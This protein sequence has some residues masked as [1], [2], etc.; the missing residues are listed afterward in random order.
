MDKSLDLKTNS[1]NF[2]IAQITTSITKSIKDKR[3]T[4]FSASLQ[5]SDPAHSPLCVHDM[6]SGLK[7]INMFS[8]NVSSYEQTPGCSLLVAPALSTDLILITGSGA[9]DG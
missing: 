5:S 6:T 7:F 2:Q 8:S 1:S 9:G 4:C 3:L